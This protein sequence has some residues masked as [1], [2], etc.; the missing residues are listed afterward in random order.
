VLYAIAFH[1]KAALYKAFSITK[2]L[3]LR[4]FASAKQKNNF[5]PYSYGYV[6]EK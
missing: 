6:E 4:I 3:V 1:Q 2:S 5:P